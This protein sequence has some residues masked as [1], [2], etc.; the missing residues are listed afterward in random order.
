MQTQRSTG[1]GCKAISYAEI[2]WA[3]M[4][5]RHLTIMSWKQEANIGILLCSCHLLYCSGLLSVLDLGALHRD[6]AVNGFV[7]YCP[8]HRF[9]FSNGALFVNAWHLPSACPLFNITFRW[10]CIA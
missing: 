6:F 5:V 9:N 4:G 7:S 2:V 3:G 8:L 10:F 1:N